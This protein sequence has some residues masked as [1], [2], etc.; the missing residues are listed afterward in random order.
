MYLKIV[1]R[2]DEI[3]DL[4]CKEIYKRL[5]LNVSADDILF[6]YDHDGN[7]EDAYVCNI[8]PNHK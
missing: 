7:L 4:L 6:N 1:I 8:Y 3:T 2:K 5:R